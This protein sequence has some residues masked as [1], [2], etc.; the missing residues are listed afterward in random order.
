MGDMTDTENIVLEELAEDANYAIEQMK[1]IDKIRYWTTAVTTS[2]KTSFRVFM[3]D[4]C[5]KITQEAQSYLLSLERSEMID[6]AT[7]ELVIDS[8]MFHSSPIVDLP[9]MKATIFMVL[10]SNL[11]EQDE[12]KQLHSIIF[13]QSGVQH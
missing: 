9:L 10:V 2:R 12:I 8:A 5:G 1:E 3:A 13:D 4:E 11:L 6:G 7:R